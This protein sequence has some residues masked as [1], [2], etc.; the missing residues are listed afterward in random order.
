MQTQTGIVSEYH[1]ESRECKR[2]RLPHDQSDSGRTL[3][4]KTFFSLLKNPTSILIGEEEERWREERCIIDILNGEDG[5]SSI[6]KILRRGGGGRGGGGGK[7][8]NTVLLMKVQNRAIYTQ[9][10]TIFT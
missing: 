1:T 2:A 10:M 7:R 3:K 6:T 5:S 8:R 4:A 9:H